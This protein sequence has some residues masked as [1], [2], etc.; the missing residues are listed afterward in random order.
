MAI[1]QVAIA[2]F[3]WATVYTGDQCSLQGGPKSKP[4]FKW[5]KNCVKSY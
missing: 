4:L 5:S 1:L 3:F 2:N